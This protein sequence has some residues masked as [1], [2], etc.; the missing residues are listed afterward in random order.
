MTGTYV[1]RSLEPTFRSALGQFPAVVVT[2]PRQA[3]KTTL[4]RHVLGSAASYVT[5]ED[6]D[7]REAALTDP[8]GFLAAYPAPLILDEVQRA[9]GV[10]AYLQTMIDA[11][12]RAVGR[13]VLTGSQN[14]ALLETV[15]ET[16]AGRAA[17]L[18]LMPFSAR[19]LDGTPNAVM[20]WEGKSRIGSTRDAPALF[21]RLLRSGFPD[22][23]LGR[24]DPT[25]WFPSYVT[26]YIE[27]DL[28]TMRQVGDL[29]TFQL[30]MRVVAARTGTILDLTDISREIGV[31]LN[32]AK[33]WLSVLVASH[34]VMLLP[35][36]HANVGKRLVKRPKLYLTDV[37]L[38]CYLT[39]ITTP[40]AAIGGPMS[41]ALFE[42]A[43]VAEVHAALL[44]RGMTP[45]LYFW[46]VSGRTEVDLLVRH[47]GRLVPLE[48]KLSATPTP[49]VAQPIAAL[50][51]LLP[52]T[53]AEL[54]YVVHPGASDLPL[55]PGARA[56]PFS[57]L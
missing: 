35:P 36:Y 47:E 10:L 1:T 4:V 42:T 51:Q 55:G 26:T 39:G 9:P 17:V 54:G 43:M 28:R 30:F 5:L 11:D 44:A 32:T 6:P 18:R 46:N 37:G 50:Q 29:L 23:A 34:L 56:L 3:G 45:E 20:P 41:G 48:A 2:G 13:Y 24:T 52:D 40:E 16:L 12:R 49:R 33:A 8:R 22:P 38:A 31:T 57:S 7:V 53:I 15:S 14:L 27:R 21:A 25:L 19:E